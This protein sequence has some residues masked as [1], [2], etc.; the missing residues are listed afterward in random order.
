MIPRLISFYVTS[1][2]AR[3]KRLWGDASRIWDKG[4]LVYRRRRGIIHRYYYESKRER[5][6]VPDYWDLPEQLCCCCCYYSA[7]G[8]CGCISSRIE[9]ERASIEF[10]TGM[11]SHR[12][13]ER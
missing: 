7:F 1:K 2:A 5:Y 10:Y 8:W 11:Y 3:R 9:R 13:G 4:C 12:A 6:S